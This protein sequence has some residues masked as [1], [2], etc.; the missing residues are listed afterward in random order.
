MDSLHIDDP[1]LDHK[2]CHLHSNTRL[3]Y[4]S[5][6]WFHI[7]VHKPMGGLSE[8]YIHTYTM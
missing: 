7:P 5:Q 6:H 1:S 2:R 3:L 8:L 4:K